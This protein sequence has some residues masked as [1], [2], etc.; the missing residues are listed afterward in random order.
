M[1]MYHQTMFGN[2][3]FSVSEHCLAQTTFYF[4]KTFV[5]TLT[6]NTAIQFFPQDILAYDD[7]PSKLNLVAKGS[8]V[9]KT[10][11]IWISWA[12]TMILTLKKANQIP[13]MA[14]QLKMMHHLS[15]FVAKGW[16]VQKM[17]NKT[18]T[19]SYGHDNSSINV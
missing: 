12:P 13:C 17:L 5:V 10:K 1:V 14:F 16:V 11:N 6:L 15:K 8:A 3:R 4:K 7:V 9:H 2:K 18:R 19:Q